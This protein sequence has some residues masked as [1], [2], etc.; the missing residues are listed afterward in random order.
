MDAGILGALIGAT[1]TL[2]TAVLAYAAARIQFRGQKRFDH[3]RAV[4]EERGA[5]YH[6]FL[7][8]VML[9]DS[10]MRALSRRF[11]GLSLGEIPDKATRIGEFEQFAA[12]VHGL[13]AS[14]SS[15]ALVG[16]DPVWRAARD[17]YHE[18]TYSDAALGM[19]CSADVDEDRRFCLDHFDGGLVALQER[20]DEFIDAARV[21][22]GRSPE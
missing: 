16:P 6:A 13:A 8:E 18:F 15:V 10:A 5:A 17:L 12:S 19:V 9:T 20:R 14:V 11:A 3:D 7:N 1:A 21:I 2:V 22:L 4:W